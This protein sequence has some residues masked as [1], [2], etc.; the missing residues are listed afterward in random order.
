MKYAVVCTSVD[1]EDLA[2]S[3]SKQAVSLGLAACVQI[4]PIESVYRWKGT[5]E[6]ARSFGAWTIARAVAKKA[7]AHIRQLSDCWCKELL[8]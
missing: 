6:T 5:V 3:M 2:R 1:T 4:V 7:L 8:G